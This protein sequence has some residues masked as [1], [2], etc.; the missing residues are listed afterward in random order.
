[1]P[2]FVARR[3]I[4][5]FSL[6]NFL[7]SPPNCSLFPRGCLPLYSTGQRKNYGFVTFETEEALVRAVSLCF[8]GGIG[9]RESE[10]SRERASKASSLAK[11]R[12]NST[13]CVLAA[14]R[15]RPLPGALG[16]GLGVAPAALDGRAL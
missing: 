14:P 2:V 4:L 15:A 12:K 6:T 1:M 10:E 8:L 11:K 3:R 5:Q 16:R 9:L 13:R 7:P